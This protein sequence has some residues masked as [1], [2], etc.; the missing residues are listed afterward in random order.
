[1]HEPFGVSGSFDDFGFE[2]RQ[3]FGEPVGK[4][5]PLIGAV[6]KQLLEKWKQAFHRRQKQEATVTLLNAGGMYDG[7]EQQTQRIYQYMA[8]LA[9]D[10]FARIIAMR[11]DAGP[12]FSALFTLW[13][14]IMAAVG[15][16]S[17]SA[18]SR[19]AT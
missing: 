18:F 16:A 14:S 12:P 15:L 3:D 11:I 8:L 7:V 4:N 19:H 6:G 10:L 5:R 9:L 13:L 2:T 1:L 17:R